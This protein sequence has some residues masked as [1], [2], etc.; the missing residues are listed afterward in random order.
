MNLKALAAF[1]LI[2]GAA[3]AQA[4]AWWPFKEQ[5]SRPSAQSAVAQ[6]AAQA[7]AQAQVVQAQAIMLPALPVYSQPAVA[8]TQMRYVGPGP[9]RRALGGLGERMAGLK[10]G[11]YLADPP[12]VTYAP[13]TATAAPQPIV[14]LVS[15]PA[16]APV[17]AATGPSPQS[18][19]AA[20]AAPAPP[21]VPGK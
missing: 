10:R 21:K 18:I 8:P 1:L 9:L 17:Q 13:Q 14:V 6:P 3:Q 2:G 11:H 7:Q 4:P 16:Q 19:Q 12:P 5:E 15:M 20:T